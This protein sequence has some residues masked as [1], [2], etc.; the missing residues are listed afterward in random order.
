MPSFWQSYRMDTRS[1]LLPILEGLHIEAW[2]RQAQL[3]HSSM[4]MCIPPPCCT[5]HSSKVRSHK[6]IRRPKCQ[7]CP[8][9]HRSI[10]HNSPK[11]CWDTHQILMQQ[12]LLVIHRIIQ[13]A[14]SALS[15][16]LALCTDRRVTKLDKIVHLV[17]T[18]HLTPRRVGMNTILP[19]QSIYRIL[20]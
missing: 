10:S 15:C 12:Q 9:H 8:V 18:S 4:V 17:M 11:A 6:V 19:F 2:H 1:R 14:I 13:V 3:F 5:H 20:Q 7:T 16:Y